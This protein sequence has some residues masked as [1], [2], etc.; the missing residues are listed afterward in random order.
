MK[1]SKRLL[2]VIF[3]TLWLPF[4]GSVIACSC[5]SA[6]GTL[7]DQVLATFNFAQS[8]VIGEVM[9]VGRQ[10]ISWLG[11]FVDGQRASVSISRVFKGEIRQGDRIQVESAMHGAMCGAPVKVGDLVL[12]YVSTTQVVRLSACGR[13]GKLLKRLDDIPVLYRLAEESGIIEKEQKTAPH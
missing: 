7:E 10:K 13:S 6:E 11:E 12:L 9:D 2:L 1:T 3:A 4:T 5:D 8:V